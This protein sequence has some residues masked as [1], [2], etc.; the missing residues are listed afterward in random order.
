M[1]LVP[2][3]ESTSRGGSLEDITFDQ[4]TAVLGTDNYTKYDDSY[5][6]K[7]SWSYLD[8]GTGRKVFVWCYKVSDAKTCKEWSCGGDH[9][10]LFQ[11]FGSKYK[12]N[13]W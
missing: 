5:K 13:I 4:I 1:K 9:S 6:V 7:A 3:Q 11:L 12:E 8:E 2:I 10:L